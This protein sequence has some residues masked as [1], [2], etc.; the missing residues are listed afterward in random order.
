MTKSVTEG[1][2]G[3]LETFE[4]VSTEYQKDRRVHTYEITYK[5]DTNSD[6]AIRTAIGLA[7]MRTYHA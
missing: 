5:E 4:L 6:L 3:C 7:M 2:F 1:R